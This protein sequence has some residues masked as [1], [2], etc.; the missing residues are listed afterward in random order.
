MKASIHWQSKVIQPDYSVLSLLSSF[1]PHPSSLSGYGSVDRF[2]TQA[3]TYKKMFLTLI[4][5]L[6]ALLMS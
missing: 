5:E 2:S 1:I 4:K 3:L 6:C